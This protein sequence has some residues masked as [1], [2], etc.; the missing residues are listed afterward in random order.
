MKIETSRQ[1]LLYANYGRNH[2]VSL[3]GTTCTQ[4]DMNLI[5]AFLYKL[6]TY[7]LHHE[8]VHDSRMVI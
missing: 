5:R 6:A 2:S 8:V 3:D 1:N 7:L 4:T